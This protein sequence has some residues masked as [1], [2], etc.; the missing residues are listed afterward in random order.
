MTGHREKCGKE[1]YIYMQA[2]L[3]KFFVEELFQTVQG[4]IVNGEN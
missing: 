4:N 1:S 3:Y 2:Q